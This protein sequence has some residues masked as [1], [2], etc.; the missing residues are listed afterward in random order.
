MMPASDHDSRPASRRIAAPSCRRPTAPRAGAAHGYLAPTRRPC[1][2]C[3]Y[4]R[5]APSRRWHKAE[6]EKLARDDG[7]TYSQ[8][9][10]LLLC[11]QKN[12]RLC[13]GWVGCHGMHHCLAIRLAAVEERIDA[14]LVARVLAY[15]CAA[16]LFSS[17]ADAAVD[18][19]AG[20]AAPDSRDQRAI[21]RLL[22]KRSPAQGRT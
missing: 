15:E 9:S 18:G 6:C 21:G 19:L 2:T 1:A 4:R 14:D 7:H 12:R 8:P 11:H 13:A 10:G 17:G 16:A 22:A 5:D 3:P 20:I